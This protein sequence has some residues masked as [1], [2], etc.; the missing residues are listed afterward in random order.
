MGRMNEYPFL[1][2]PVPQF[3][4]LECRDTKTQLGCQT[5]IIK[6]YALFTVKY[7]MRLDKPQKIF[8]SFV[9]RVL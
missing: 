9:Q 1:D 6:R 4:H 3:F 2:H 8:G 5:L 7:D